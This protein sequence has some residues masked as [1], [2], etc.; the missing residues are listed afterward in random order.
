MFSVAL[1]RGTGKVMSF[2]IFPFLLCQ[3]VLLPL[4]VSVP[5]PEGLKALIVDRYTL[6]TG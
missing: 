1:G 6:L 2:E 5:L 3:P 4:S